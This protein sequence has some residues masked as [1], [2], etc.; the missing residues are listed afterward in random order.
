MEKKVIIVQ[1][2]LES[3]ARFQHFIQ[4]EYPRL[5]K[6]VVYTDSFE[7]TLYVAPKEGELVVISCNTF[8]D[9]A[10]DFSKLN[11]TTIPEYLKD[12]VT[13]AK[14]IKEKNSNT[15]FYLFTKQIVERNEYLDEFIPQ[16]PFGDIEVADV[17]NVLDK[18]G[19]YPK[20]SFIR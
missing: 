10:S 11:K 20:M 9:R 2:S 14:M 5:V 3:I 19:F 7:E 1:T 6:D 18:I 4:Q 17:L 12:G 13:L 15:R 16:N 8:N